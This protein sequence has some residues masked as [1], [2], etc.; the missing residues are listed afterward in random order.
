[1]SATRKILL[2]AVALGLLLNPLFHLHPLASDRTLLQ[3]G[4]CKYCL[5]G[6]GLV[7]TPEQPAALPSLSSAIV[8]LAIATTVLSF[9]TCTASSR[10]PP[11]F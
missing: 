4:T 6:A 10:A 11:L 2:M 3:G 8:T 5:S 7:F 1:M 9:E